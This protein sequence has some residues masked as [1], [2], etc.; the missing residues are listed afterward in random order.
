MTSIISIDI[1]RLSPRGAVPLP[2][3]RPSSPDVAS[4]GLHIQG[5][6]FLAESLASFRLHFSCIRFAYA[7]T[8]NFWGELA[9]RYVAEARTMRQEGK[10]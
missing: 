1:N 2:L 10:N 6:T 3:C 8:D 9:T 4:I 7:Y 5:F